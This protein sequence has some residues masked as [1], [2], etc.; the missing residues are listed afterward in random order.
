MEQN[1]G[2]RGTA[3]YAAALAFNLCAGIFVCV[4]VALLLLSDGRAPLSSVGY[5][6]MAAG[7]ALVFPAMI[8]LA[9]G[10]RAGR[11]FRASAS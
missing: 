11:R 6:L 3:L 8:R 10:V 9:Q 4:G 2:S 7:V 1:Y 5:A